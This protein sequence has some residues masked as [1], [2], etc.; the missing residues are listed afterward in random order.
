MSASE[1]ASWV[2]YLRAECAWGWALLFKHSLKNVGIGLLPPVQPHGGA[3]LGTVGEEKAAPPYFS[4]T[5]GETL[6]VCG[7]PEGTRLKPAT[8]N[9]LSKANASSIPRSRI[10]AKLTASA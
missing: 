4:D 8:T 10:R 7:Y 6:G 1:L 9:R 3:S 5:L 2:P